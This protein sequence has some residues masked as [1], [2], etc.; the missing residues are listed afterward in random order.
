MTVAFGGM[1]SYM[2][3]PKVPVAGSGP[4]R[5]IVPGNGHAH[6]FEHATVDEYAAFVA[7]VVIVFLVGVWWARL[8][9]H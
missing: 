5:G 7:V 9:R 3:F 2:T 1:S 4:I 8:R 6:V